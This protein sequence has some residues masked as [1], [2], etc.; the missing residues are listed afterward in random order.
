MRTDTR[1]A[2]LIFCFFALVYSLLQGTKPGYTVDANATFRLTAE[3]V[4]TGTISTDVRAKQG[5]FHAI[6]YVPFYVIGDIVARFHPEANPDDVRRRALCWMNGVLSAAVCAVLY[7]ICREFGA[8]ASASRNV[9][10]AAG[11]ST[12][13]LP[14]ARYDY[15]KVPAELLVCL[16]LLSAWRVS[17]RGKPAD[18]VLL[19][20]W[21]GLLAGIRLELLIIVP[22]LV[23]FILYQRRT[24]L[25]VSKVLPAALVAL[26]FVGFVFWYQWSRW[27]GISGYE[28]G[29]NRLPI[30]GMYGLLFSLGKSIFLYN[31]ILVCLPWVVWKWRKSDFVPIW[32]LAVGPAFLLYSWWSNWWGGWAWG[33]RHLLPIIPLLAAPLAV[34]F[35]ETRSGIMRF[36]FW[37][38]TALGIAIQLLGITI[39]FNDGINTLYKQGVT[40]PMVIYLWPFGGI[41]NH[42]KLI[43]RIPFIVCD[44]G[45]L[46]YFLYYPSGRVFGLAAGAALLALLCLFRLRVDYKERHR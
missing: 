42:A 28:G 1:N 30:V 36:F 37:Y 14:Y 9:A 21:V 20:L 27:R 33:P 25:N 6:A 38:L 4:H 41:A 12:M 5:I 18:F 34:A 31:P 24:D 44:F 16:L 39:D 43:A 15:N 8:A 17:K 11:L 26:L 35:T 22:F 32:L 10:L 19:G 40:E 23:G 3:L 46:R 13:I 45:V 2:W 7:L 29:F